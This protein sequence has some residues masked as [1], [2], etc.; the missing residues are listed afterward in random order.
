MSKGIQQENPILNNIN[1][2]YFRNIYLTSLKW[3][4]QQLCNQNEVYQNVNYSFSL[5]EID[6]LNKNHSFEVQG[7]N[8]QSILYS[9]SEYHILRIKGIFQIINRIHSI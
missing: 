6:N 9:I 1:I 7:L 2:V 3:E 5:F 4:Y 8:F